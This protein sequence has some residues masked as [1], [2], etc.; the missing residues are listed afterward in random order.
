[1]QWPCLGDQGAG[2]DDEEETN[3]DW[4]EGEQ[5]AVHEGDRGEG[6]LHR[7]EM[8][9]WSKLIVTIIGSL[10][11]IVCIDDKGNYVEIG[12]K[13]SESSWHP[14]ISQSLI[15]I[16]SIQGYI[17]TVEAVPMFNPITHGYSSTIILFNALQISIEYLE[18]L[19]LCVWLINDILNYWLLMI[20]ISYC[21]LIGYTVLRA[22]SWRRDRNVPSR[23]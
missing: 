12:Y 6:H 2:C 4:Y 17:R 11:H 21:S 5:E 7:Q 3:R 20:Y 10:W 18:G 9:K 19:K 16:T 8:S 1:M 14:Y 22:I 23:N 13:P 15:L